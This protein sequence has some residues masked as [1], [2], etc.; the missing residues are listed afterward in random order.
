MLFMSNEIFE[1]STKL[2]ENLFTITELKKS[3]KSEAV[4]KKNLFRIVDT[5]TLKGFKVKNKANSNM[6]KVF[7]SKSPKEGS[8]KEVASP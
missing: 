4:D 6:N 3:T 8:Q 7:S 1:F 5:F 2:M